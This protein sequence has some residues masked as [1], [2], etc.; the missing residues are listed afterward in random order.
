MLHDIKIEENENSN[1][2]RLVFLIHEQRKIY[3]ELKNDN[4]NFKRD[5]H[6][7]DNLIKQ[8]LK[9]QQWKVILLLLAS[10]CPL[11]L[12]RI[13]EL[14]N[15]KDKIFSTENLKAQTAFGQ[16]VVGDSIKDADVKSSNISK[17]AYFKRGIFSPQ[18]TRFFE[19]KLAGALGRIH[20][21]KSQHEES[22]KKFARK[23]AEI[24]D[25]IVRCL[26]LDATSANDKSLAKKAV[27]VLEQ[28]LNQYL[29]ATDP[30]KYNPI[31]LI[32][33][34]YALLVDKGYNQPINN[35][36]K[37]THFRSFKTH[38]GS[39]KLDHSSGPVGGQYY[40]KFGIHIN[41]HSTSIDFLATVIHEFTHGICQI[42][43]KDIST[44]YQSELKQLTK[45]LHGFCKKTGKSKA[46]ILNFYDHYTEKYHASEIFPRIVELYI[47]NPDFN[48]AFHYN[49]EIANAIGNLFSL[50]LKDMA[51]FKAKLLDVQIGNKW[52]RKEI[53][54]ALE[55][56]DYK[57][58]FSMLTPENQSQIN[59]WPQLMSEDEKLFKAAFE[60]GFPLFAKNK[61]GKNSL[62]FAIESNT[63]ESAVEILHYL[64]EHK[65]PIPK[66]IDYNVTDKQGYSLLMRAVDKEPEP[67]FIKWLIEKVGIDVGI[68][69]P[70]TNKT[71]LSYASQNKEILS[72]ILSTLT[73]HSLTPTPELS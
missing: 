25:T 48:I 37:I 19:T 61:F 8:A 43:Y 27:S 16:R 68:A 40:G 5:E 46:D 29:I 35:E 17:L 39:P 60:K 45:V 3:T 62:K 36:M 59:V 49:E 4:R 71:A 15:Y 20:E 18:P 64:W 12:E 2:E 13:N 14:A 28:L 9:E 6:D 51:E 22:R 54:K 53:S 56:K 52:S 72:V 58:V 57:A 41:P 38:M 69:N 24:L 21:E 31:L 34:M 26:G 23:N 65:L 7:L 47:V 66:D 55:I 1:I 44:R 30:N 33:E 73:S 63:F 10:P 67:S 11:S 32:L 42:I 70:F 50:F